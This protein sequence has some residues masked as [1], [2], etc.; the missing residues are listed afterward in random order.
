MLCV[1]GHYKYYNSFSAG[2]IS[3]GMSAQRIAPIINKICSKSL[4]SNI[5][6]EQWKTGILSPLFKKGAMNEPGIDR[7]ISVL[8]ILSKVFNHL[9]EFLSC[10][11]FLSSRQYGFRR[12][13]SCE[14]AL[15]LIIDDWLN[16]LHNDDMIGVN[17]IAFCNALHMVD[18]K[19]LLEKIKLYNIRQNSLIWFTFYLSDITQY[20]KYY[21]NICEPLRVTYGVPQGSILGPLLF[22]CLSMIHL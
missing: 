1:Y 9:Y 16:S 18:N 8:P 3:A 12:N 20:V 7:S 21:S 5:S 14:T 19:I 13:H 22:L 10:N 4:K 11:D 6:P 15:N 17:V 2:I